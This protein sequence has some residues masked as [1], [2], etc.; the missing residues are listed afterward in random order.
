M[1][2]CHTS[3]SHFMFHAL[4]QAIRDLL[5][6]RLRFRGK[7]ATCCRSCPKTPCIQLN[8]GA[9]TDDAA[10]KLKDGAKGAGS[11]E[12]VDWQPS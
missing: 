6:P 2:A 11:R 1:A 3:R 9:S 10:T 4:P 5:K 8:N 12:R 7:D